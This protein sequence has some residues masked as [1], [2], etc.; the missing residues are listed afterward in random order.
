ENALSSSFF[1]FFQLLRLLVPGLP[2]I[3]VEVLEFLSDLRR[4]FHHRILRL[5]ARSLESPRPDAAFPG[6]RS[7]ALA[8]PT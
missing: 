8:D 4:D 1:S 3:S 7:V 5:D 6:L 2:R